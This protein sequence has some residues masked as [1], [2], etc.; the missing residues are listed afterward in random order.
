[1]VQKSFPWDDIEGDRLYNSRDFRDFFATFM[2]TG[3]IQSFGDG[4]RVQSVNGMRVVA[5]IGSAMI[6][7]GSFKN[8]EPLAFNI[9][10]SSN[11]QDRYDSVVV[12][13]D[14]QV[15]NSYIWYKPN[16]TTV[17][18][19]GTYFDIQLAVIKVAKNATQITNADITDKRSN[20]TVCGWSTP[21]DNINVD[22]VVEQYRAIFQ[23]GEAEFRE[24]FKNLQNMLSTNQAT[25]LQNQINQSIADKGELPKGTDLNSFLDMGF[26]TLNYVDH[27][28]IPNLPP[29]FWISSHSSVGW[30][31]LLVFNSTK[32]TGTMTTQTV[33]DIKGIYF[34]RFKANSEA[35]WTEWVTDVTADSSG[36]VE[37]SGT[38]KV[39]KMEVQKPIVEPRK[40]VDIG[41]IGGGLSANVERRGNLVEVQ[42][43]GTS[44][45]VLPSGTKFVVAKIPAGF[46]PNKTVNVLVHLTG[47][48]GSGHIDVGADGQMIWFGS[49]IGGGHHPRGITMYFT[50]D[51][52]PE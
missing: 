15:R 44:N 39:Q 7:G 13:W 3:V 46:R 38:L 33:Q 49:A 52:F 41:H 9:N 25:N 11:V 42:I 10:V 6:E 45:Q 21:F 36:N 47:N 43:Y 40:A 17:L 29:N 20:P 2:K 35:S 50:D 19:N 26:Y 16:D 24:W 4:L 48:D 12:R 30:G 31:H 23:K 37:I 1:M 14:E 18:R 27:T 5:G 8:T 32:D 22:S 28:T 51:P 34:T